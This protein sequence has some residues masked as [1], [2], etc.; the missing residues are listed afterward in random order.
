MTNTYKNDFDKNSAEYD[1]IIHQDTDKGNTAIALIQNPYITNSE[2]YEAHG[3]DEYGNKYLVTWKI[4]D[5]YLGSNAEE[6][7]DESEACN[8]ENF[9]I[10]CL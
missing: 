1:C 5:C 7:N 2:S 3:I 8:W 10:K 6:I 4:Y 9:E